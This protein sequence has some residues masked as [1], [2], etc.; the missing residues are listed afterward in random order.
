[1][2]EILFN[3]WFWIYIW[4]I[5]SSIMIIFIP[6]HQ[7]DLS[8]LKKSIENLKQSLIDEDEKINQNFEKIH[9]DLN[10]VER[11]INQMVVLAKKIDK[12][13]YVFDEN[14]KSGDNHIVIGPSYVRTKSLKPIGKKAKKFLTINGEIKKKYRDNPIA[15]KCY[16]KF[17]ALKQD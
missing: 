17:Q 5:A 14:L 1:M 15:Q 12:S 2:T 9:K 16:Q 10:T 4:A 8:H 13:H 11:E 6:F 7:N 3:I